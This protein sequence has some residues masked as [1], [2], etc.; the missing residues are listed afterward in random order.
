MHRYNIFQRTILAASSLLTA[1]L[2]LLALLWFLSDGVMPVQA[3]PTAELHVCP[4]GS[5]TCD[6]ASVQAAVDAASPGDLIKVAT[7]VYT[8][9]NGYGGLSQVIYIS[10]T[11][12]LRGGYTTADWDTSD[13]E[14][15]PTTLYA[16]GQ[17]RVAYITGAISPTLEGLRL[18]GGDATWLGEVYMVRMLAVG[19]IFSRPRW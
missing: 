16:Q 4:S 17:G 6:Y 1:G 8:G 14:A 13:P 9:V 5:P 15:N 3:A 19:C 10:K 7:G 2:I 11:V 18:T 12:T